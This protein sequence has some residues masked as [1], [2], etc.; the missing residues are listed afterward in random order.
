MSRVTEEQIA[1]AKQWDLL[2]YLQ[3]FEPAELVRSSTNEYCTK[4][5]DSLKI[6]HGLWCWNSRGIG[7]KSALD[8][9]IKVREMDF[10]EAVET[11]CGYR[12][13]LKTKTPPPLQSKPFVLPE[14]SVCPSAVVPYLRKRGIDTEIISACWNAGILYESRRYRNCVFV[15]KDT[16]G[17][18]R[19]ACLRGTRGSFK[20]DVPGSDKRFSFCLPASDTDCPRLAVAESPIDA[21]SLATL[22]YLNGENWRECNYLS[23]SGTAPRALLQYL[24]DHPQISQISLCLDN[25]KAGMDGMERL[26]KAV[27]DNPALS[28]RVDLIYRNPPPKEHGKD[29]NEFL[30]A[31]NYKYNAVN[32]QKER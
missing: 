25:D 20:R 27:R 29:Y 3:T 4:T 6:S 22:V 8:Y 10:V 23:L 30:I 18:A 28:R 32:R 11:L 12:A 16:Q 5:H 1:A 7:G 19:F 24:Q 13:P 15:G 9:L 31:Q 21:L 14:A 2:T 17:R 26:E